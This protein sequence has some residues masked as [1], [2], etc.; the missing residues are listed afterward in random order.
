M[1]STPAVVGD[2]VCIGS[3]A[4]MFYALDRASGLPRG[5]HD[6]FSADSVHRQFHGDPLLD[7]DL[8]LIGTDAGEGD[9]AFVFA[10]EPATANVRW[11]RAMGPGVASDLARWK[12]RRYAVTLMDE[13][14]CFDPASG[15]IHWSHRSAA[16]VRNDRASAP[17]IVGDRVVH[18]DRDGILRAY[19]AETGR[20]LWR[21]TQIDPLTT[22]MVAADSSLMFVRG[23]GFLVRLDPG[24]G[25]ESRRNRIDG[26]PYS[27]AITNVGDSLI[28]LAGAGRLTAFDLNHDRV[29]WSRSA[30]QEWTSSRPY[31]WRDMAL[32]GD[33][34]RL[35]AYRLA[36][37]A[38]RW[39]HTV[40]GVVRG[41]GV[42]G[43]T[44]YVGTL[45]GEVHALV[46]RS[47]HPASGP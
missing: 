36:D 8:L 39:T 35:V 15:A 25:R 30:I 21:T 40:Q 33:Q 10:F 38:L 3:C 23:S 46:D 18:A 28:L 41:I 12:D 43:D 13:L 19:D 31:V 32:A 1:F 45:K 47:E 7:N 11:K 4:G 37:G 5:Q 26:G 2:V 14:V 27:G 6:V 29:R 17:V 44:L 20:L 22:W 16:S 34:G 9:T 24:T 42:W